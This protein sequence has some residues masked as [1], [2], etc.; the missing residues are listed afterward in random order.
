MA[1]HLVQVASLVGKNVAGLRVD[2]RERES[3]GRLR[4]MW[5]RT[6]AA[7]ATLKVVE[8]VKRGA[9]HTTKSTHGN[10]LYW[11]YDGYGCGYS[12][13]YCDGSEKEIYIVILEG[14]KL[15]D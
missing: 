7:I 2:I 6:P 11:R 8:I 1:D 3:T 12:G 13:H 15:P 10:W 5:E 9:K 4:G 14:Q